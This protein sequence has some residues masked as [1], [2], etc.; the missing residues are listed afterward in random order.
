MPERKPSIAGLVDAPAAELAHDGPNLLSTVTKL[1]EAPHSRRNGKRRAKK[2]GLRLG[3]DRLRGTK[4]E[5]A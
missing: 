3:S 5:E 2:R 1:V 4:Y